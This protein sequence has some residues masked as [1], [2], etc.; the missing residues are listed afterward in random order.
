MDTIQFC[1]H[2]N[3]HLLV[4]FNLQNEYNSTVLLMKAEHSAIVEE[5]HKKIAHLELNI[6]SHA[7]ISG[8]E[9]L[10][11][12]AMTDEDK[13]HAKELAEKNDAA[14]DMDVKGVDCVIQTDLIG[15]CINGCQD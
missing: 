15:Q 12:E 9:H 13:L 7:L 4:C 3:S 11:L 10:T 14:A 1:C 2:L 8:L 6:E 5:L